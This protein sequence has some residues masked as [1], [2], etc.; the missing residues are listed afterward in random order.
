[1]RARGGSFGSS[2]AAALVMAGAAALGACASGTGGAP[3][4]V[5]AA[6]GALSPESAVSQFLDAVRRN[7][8][9][10]MGRL[11]GTV[12]GPAEEDMGRVQVEQRMFVLASLLRHSSF[13]IRPTQMAEAENKTRL[14]VDMVG[15]RNGDVSVPFVASTDGGR[16][17]VERIL[18]DAL[19]G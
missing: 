16:W 11:F 19:S 3:P 9:A 8:Y 10:L 15:T 4:T 14:I 17:F 6:Y 12:D 2:T 1:M 13:E 7:D 5:E 18:T